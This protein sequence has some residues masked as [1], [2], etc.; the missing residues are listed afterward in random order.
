MVLPLLLVQLSHPCFSL[1]SKASLMVWHWLLSCCCS[2]KNNLVES[3]SNVNTCSPLNVAW[4]KPSKDYGK[5]YF[6]IIH[7]SIVSS[8]VFEPM[9]TIWWFPWSF[10]RVNNW[11]Y[12]SILMDK[13]LLMKYMLHLLP[14]LQPM[15]TILPLQRIW[16]E[17]LPKFRP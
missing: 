13:S 15:T 16:K 3:L 4:V 9:I 2:F 7:S 5:P 10:S 8:N 6:N 14:V 11:R 1:V 12:F 17:F